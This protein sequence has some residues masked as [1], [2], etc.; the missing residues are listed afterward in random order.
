MSARE[1][2]VDAYGS[3]E[4]WTRREGQAIQEGNW[5]QVGECQRTKRGLQERIL[6]LTEALTSLT[7]K[8]Q[9]PKSG[10]ASQ[11][12]GT[13]DFGLETILKRL[14]L[15]ETRNT[16]LVTDRRQAAESQKAEME[17]AFRNLR[18]VKNSYVQ[19]SLVAWHSYS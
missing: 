5:I 12:L 16:Q 19:P 4:Q 7:S 1:N 8:V 3:W 6:R 11:R 10:E 9:S 14:I 13:L 15:L 2:L 17:N 18:R